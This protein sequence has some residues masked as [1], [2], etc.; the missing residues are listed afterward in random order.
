[1]DVEFSPFYGILYL[2]NGLNMVNVSY[3]F[4]FIN[5]KKIAL[6]QKTTTSRF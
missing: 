5:A 1:M 6:P 3:K 4:I 2:I